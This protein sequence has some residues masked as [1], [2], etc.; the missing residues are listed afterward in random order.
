MK[1][2][3]KNQWFFDFL[4]VLKN[5]QFTYQNRLLERKKRREIRRV[6]GYIHM[7]ITDGYL[8]LLLRTAKHWPYS[9]G[10]SQT[11]VDK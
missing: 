5:L 7:M 6:S 4:K 11:K 3:A 8:S 1:E 9:V 10:R 2:P